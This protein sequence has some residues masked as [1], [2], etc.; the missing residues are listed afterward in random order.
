MVFVTESRVDD[1]AVEESDEGTL[2]R[3]DPDE[4]G[5]YQIF[6]DV[7]IVLDVLEKL[8]AG[9]P[10]VAVSEFDGGGDLVSFVVE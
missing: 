2:H 10:F 6:A 5:Q 3:V 8:P 7:K 4:L 9:A 1:A